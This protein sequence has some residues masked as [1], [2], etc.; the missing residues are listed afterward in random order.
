MTHDTCSPTSNN[1]LMQLDLLDVFSKT[2]QDTLRWDSPQSSATWKNWVTKQRG[3]Y[4][5]RK[6]LEHTTK[7]NE[8]L[9]WQTPTTTDIQRTPEYEDRTSVKT[10]ALMTEKQLRKKMSNLTTKVKWETANTMDHYFETVIAK[11]MFPTPM[12][13]EAGQSDDLLSNLVNKNGDPVG[14]N[15]R[16]YDKRTGALVQMTLNRKIALQQKYPT[17]TVGEEK[18]RLQG[19]SQASKCLEAKARKGELQQDM[20]MSL[21]PYW[22]EALM[23]LPQGWTALD[24]TEKEMQGTW[25]DNSW[26]EGI[27]R[28][29]NDCPNRTDRIRMCGNGVVPQTACIAWRILSGKT[30]KQ[31]S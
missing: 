8:Y 25:A 9:S 11:Q 10:M 6:K 19:N 2:S 13:E 20:Q 5:V 16:A 12:V 31:V 1:T 30:E 18:Y 23:G 14:E 4:S 15:E 17:P 22:V 3:E 27:P 26:E 28:V 24:G 21:N 29:I 7:E